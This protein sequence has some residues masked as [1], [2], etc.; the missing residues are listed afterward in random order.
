MAEASRRV[1]IDIQVWNACGV[2][3]LERGDAEAARPWLE[4]ALEASRTYEI[5][6]F[7]DRGEAV[8]AC[9]LAMA[10]AATDACR[11]LDTVMA[12]GVSMSAVSPAETEAWGAEA[13]LFCT[14]A[15]GGG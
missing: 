6:L 15:R 12:H 8:L 5:S 7:R 10:G 13:Y 1:F 14:A 3:Q 4:R 11:L 2:V 9:A